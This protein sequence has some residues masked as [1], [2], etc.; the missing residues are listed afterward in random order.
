M[1]DNPYNFGEK[2]LCQMGCSIFQDNEHILN[3]PLLSKQD[4]KMNIEYISN[5]PIYKKKEILK[6]FIEHNEKIKQHLRDAVTTV[7]PL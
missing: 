7:N 2:I 5:G 6:T 1:N 3:C 4:F